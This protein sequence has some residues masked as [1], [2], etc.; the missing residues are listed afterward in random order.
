MLLPKNENSKK[1]ELQIHFPSIRLSVKLICF[2]IRQLQTVPSNWKIAGKRT[3]LSCE[4]M[5]SCFSLRV[6]E[7]IGSPSVKGFSSTAGVVL[8]NST[9][10]TQ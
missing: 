3:P 5:R 1:K 10:N 7:F 4:K 8:I 9:I 6:P 2:E